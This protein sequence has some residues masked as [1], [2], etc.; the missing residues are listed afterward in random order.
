MRQGGHQWN[1]IVG[2]TAPKDGYRT[3]INIVVFE[4]NRDTA[5]AS[6]RSVAE[7]HGYRDCTINHITKV[8]R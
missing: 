7:S 5:M 1:T 8:V 2:A 6:A 3:S 4:T